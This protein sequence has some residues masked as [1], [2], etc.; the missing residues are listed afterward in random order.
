MS[1]FIFNRRT[2]IT[3]IIMILLLVGFHVYSSMPQ[4]KTISVKQGSIAETVI[5]SGS[6]Q[7]NEQQ[8]LTFPVS[9]KLAYLGVA[10]N[11]VVKQGQYIGSLDK[12][13]FQKQQDQS[14]EN[15]T[16][17]RITFDQTIANNNGQ[18][19]ASA[20]NDTEKRTLQTNQNN[21][22]VSVLNVE[23]ADLQKQNADLYSPIDGVVTDVQTKPGTSV[24]AGTTAIVTIANP[25]DIYF[26]AQVGQSDIANVAVGQTASVELDAYPR[27]TFPGQVTEVDDA[28]TSTTNGEIYKVKILLHINKHIKI[29]MSGDAT[30]TTQM[31]SSALII[32]AAELIPQ[33]SGYVVLTLAGKNVNKKTVTVGLRDSNGMVEILSGLSSNDQVI[34]NYK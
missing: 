22:D 7:S 28:A 27:Q 14:L 33:G 32:P 5:A 3:A 31:D 10:K 34:T 19:P 21:L 16:N 25:N 30:I 2:L 8:T 29:N 23:I 26:E 18:T 24:V 13:I 20:V 11:D 15:Y 6:M 17:Q 9:G 12:H 4:Y 1:R